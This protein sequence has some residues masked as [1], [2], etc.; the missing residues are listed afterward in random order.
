MQWLKLT[1]FYKGKY[2][3]KSLHP[4]NQLHTTYL[5]G[6]PVMPHYQYEGSDSVVPH[7]H[8]QN[9]CLVLFSLLSPAE[10]KQNAVL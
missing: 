4:E 6:H 2:F 5:P 3:S 7:E 8:F 9:A 10:Y 1:V